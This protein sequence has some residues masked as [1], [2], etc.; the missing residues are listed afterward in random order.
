MSRWSPEPGDW[1]RTARR[2]PVSTYDMLTG[3]GLPLGTRGLVRSY[4]HGRL[5]VDLDT[6]WGTVTV[7]LR[8]RD[9]FVVRAGG[10]EQ[11]FRRRA[12]RVLLVRA[13]VLAG[14]HLP[15]VLFVASYA[16]Q[17]GTLDGVQGALVLAAIDSAFAAVEAAVHSPQQALL[18]YGVVALLLRF[19]LGRR[20]RRR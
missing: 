1:V 2:L 7:S 15:L 5:V 16:W 20:H 10:G 12:S 3:D 19:A 11:A 14:L 18:Y 6:G 17:R 8:P 13:S 9:C 4:R